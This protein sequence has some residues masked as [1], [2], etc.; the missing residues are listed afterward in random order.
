VNAYVNNVNENMSVNNP[1]QV[2]L[3]QEVL[4]VNVDHLDVDVNAEAMDMNNVNENVNNPKQVLLVNV[5]HMDIIREDDIEIDIVYA[6]RLKR[7]HQERGENG[8]K[9]K[10]VKLDKE[11]GDILEK[12]KVRK[13]TEDACDNKD[14][15]KF[16]EE[17]ENRDVMGNINSESSYN[18]VNTSEE[19]AGFQ[20]ASEDA[21]DDKDTSVD[22]F[23]DEDTGEGEDDDDINPEGK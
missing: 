2:L 13:V 20:D 4:P 22:V 8:K 6:P 5:D 16:G 21:F 11:T 12:E 19:E 3:S 14:T 7:T 10:K 15:E 23:A 9:V 1:E 17:S 18:E